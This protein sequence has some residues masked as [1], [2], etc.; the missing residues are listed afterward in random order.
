MRESELR[1]AAN[2]ASDS[3]RADSCPSRAIASATI[4]SVAFGETLG[5]TKC[6]SLQVSTKV[7]A[8]AQHGKVNVTSVSSESEGVKTFRSNSSQRLTRSGTGGINLLKCA[9]LVAHG[10][11]ANDDGQHEGLR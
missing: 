9:V 3:L 8:T 6:S 10:Q 4:E 5:V 7:D 2:E 11:Y 1:G